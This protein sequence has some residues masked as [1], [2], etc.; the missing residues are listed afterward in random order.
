VPSNTFRRIRGVYSIPQLAPQLTMVPRFTAVRFGTGAAQRKVKSTN[1]KRVDIN[2]TKPIYSRKDIE[3]KS[4]R[5]PIRR[6]ESV[7]D[8]IPPAKEPEQNRGREYKLWARK[9]IEYIGNYSHRTDGAF[10]P[11]VTKGIPI[12][13]FRQDSIDSLFKP[14][15]SVIQRCKSVS[16]HLK[17]RRN[18]I[19]FGEVV[20]DADVLMVLHRF[21]YAHGRSK[22]S[23]V[24]DISWTV[25]I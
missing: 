12:H 20:V 15:R 18:R 17:G 13:Y 11:Q 21:E 22:I 1:S 25:A 4:L 5:Q 23:Y 14:R 9:K 8:N 10:A 3:P 24:V 16:Q 6:S 19:G 2:F 7:I